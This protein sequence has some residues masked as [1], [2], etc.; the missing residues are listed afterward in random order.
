M[1]RK[2]PNCG[3]KA[4]KRDEYCASCGTRLPSPV[5]R[6][7][8]TAGG[9]KDARGKSLSQR[10]REEQ[11]RSD[12]KVATQRQARRQAKTVQDAIAFEC[13]FDDG[14]ALVEEGVYSQ[15]LYVPD[16]NFRAARPSEQDGI[17]QAMCNFYNSFPADVAVQLL[18]LN[19]VSDASDRFDEIKLPH[20]RRASED[21]LVDDYNE[22]LSRQVA[23]V[24]KNE[25]V[26]S[27]YF[28]FAI[29][30]ASHDAAAVSLST[31]VTSA[32][33]QLARFGAKAHQLTA[34]ELF[35]L[36]HELLRPGEPLKT[37]YAE[38]MAAG[39]D[40]K[41]AVSPSSLD[42][43]PDGPAGKN[44]MWTAGASPR[45]TA[46][47]GV[48][49][50]VWYQALQF[51]EPYPSSM[52]P[53]LIG[54]I[55]SLPIPMAFVIDIHPIE[56]ADAIRQVQ[57][58]YTFMKNQD[59][60]EGR[61][62][63]AQGLD[64][65]TARGIELADNMT[66][67][68]DVL[69]ALKNRNERYFTTTMVVVMWDRD[70]E[71]L[72]QSSF[73]VASEANKRV[74]TVGVPRYQSRDAMNSM[75]PFANDCLSWH[76]HM[77]TT[78]LATLLPFVTQEISEPGGIYYGNNALSGNLILLNRRRLTAPMG[79]I[80]GKPGGGKSFAAKQ[81]IFSTAISHP[82]DDVLI[83]DPKGEYTYITD[84]L[85][86]QT[87]DL[88]AGSPA[89]IN[90]FDLNASYSPDGSDPVVFKSEFVT[91]T[92]TSL[93]GETTVNSRTKS[94]IDK[95]VVDSFRLTRAKMGPDAMPTLTTF[96]QI[97]RSSDDEVA[98]ELANDL[99]IYVTGTLKTFAY[100]TNVDISSRI[101]DVS[102][103]RLQGDLMLFGQLVTLDAFWNRVTKNHDEGKRTWIYI[104]EA[105]NF[106]SSD[107]ALAYFTKCWSEGR[108]YGLIP[109]GITQNI[110][111]VIHNSEAK[112]MFSNSD[113]VMLLRQSANDLA[114]AAEIY[115]LS[116]AQAQRVRDCSPGEGLLVA[117][118]SV[119]PF[120][121]K[122]PRDTELYEIMDTDPNAAEDK[123]RAKLAAAG[124]GR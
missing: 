31:V 64:P 54:G 2:C 104:D 93:L 3:R 118:G 89:H 95:A 47:G 109:T 12:A 79:W 117:G 77:L 49:T 72:E 23:K 24:G 119:I 46:G 70:R 102:M 14:I 21:Q 71:R 90:L 91:S 8:R 114:A 37:G 51:T 82:D 57:K 36:T 122:F 113:F 68:E 34:D 83:I 56:P 45:Q 52:D 94:V 4:G 99:E 96:W 63:A 107:A 30:A 76:R 7:E 18:V 120:V 81:E 53:S 101:V 9:R 85:G 69:D 106:F 67:A 123:R 20:T 111:R 28:T 39:V 55:M 74:F 33:E 59:A 22:M 124:G 10:I 43:T 65:V 5:A 16:V 27:R 62:A 13:I 87:V 41:D 6:R 110:D 115:N 60:H 108:S 88:F 61:K 105:Q 112:H 44:D 29:H 48:S 103:K 32:L 100:P 98:S 58:K 11:R 116:A 75:L 50:V 1:T 92:I 40:I 17:W 73:R 97:L 84:M 38:L 25:I 26:R 80:I 66:E 19:R 121:N 86:G 35:R 42:F 15:T 78:E